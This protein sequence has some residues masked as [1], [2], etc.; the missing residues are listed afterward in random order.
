M[1]VLGVTSFIMLAVVVQ[2]RYRMPIEPVPEEAAASANPVA[3]L[4]K[5]LQNSLQVARISLQ[6]GHRSAAL[7][8]LNAAHHAVEPGK[9]ATCDKLFEEAFNQIEETRRALQN[10]QPERAPEILA[11][12]PARAESAPPASPAFP[13]NPSDYDGA[14]VIN[15]SGLRIGEVENVKADRAELSLGLQDVLGFIELGGTKVQVPVDRLLFG[16]KKGV[17]PTMVCLP[18]FAQKPAEIRRALGQ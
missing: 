3:T 12:D 9:G 7:H 11:R 16:K 2:A 10:G 18:V 8:A 4:K 17:G 14:T 15:A 1:T 13:A 6:A 5:G